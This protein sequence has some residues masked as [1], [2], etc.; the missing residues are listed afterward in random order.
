MLAPVDAGSG[1]RVIVIGAGIGGLS[2]AIAL[3]RAGI[4]VAVFEQSSEL[5]EVGAGVG[6]QL[7]A[8]KALKRIG[9][10]E[11]IMAVSSE[12]LQALELRNWRTGKVLAKLPQGEVAGDVGLF[13]LNIHRGDLLATLAE[14]AGEV[15]TLGAQ[16]VSCE[17][18]ANGVTARFSDGREERGAILVGADGLHSTIR[19]ALHGEP[20]LR[21]SGY[22]VWRSMPPFRDS[23]LSEGYPQ[24]AVGPGGGFGLHPKG[25]LVYWFASM[26][27]PEGAPVDPEGHKHELRGLYGDWYSP[28]PE[29]IEATP[30]DHIFQGDIYDL[31]PLARWGKGRATLLGDAAHATT[32]ALGQGAGMSIEDGAVLAEELALDPRLTSPTKITA[33]LDAYEGRRR[34]RATAIVNE[35]YRLSKTYCWKRPAAVQ[36]RETVMRLRPAASWRKTFRAEADRDL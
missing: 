33:A 12:P 1:N 27:R 15:V 22:T 7:G 6:L 30:E 26:A 36:L 14:H 32:P 9:M 20:V 35:S 24:Q 34:P 11:P 13:A 18:D 5:K 19:R 21:Y 3:R 31:K 23:R 29:L 28:I 25:D 8:V 16:C 17:Q 2:A 4:P 10:L